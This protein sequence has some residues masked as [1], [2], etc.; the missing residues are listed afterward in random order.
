MLT[1]TILV[2]HTVGIQ[3]ASG[4]ASLEGTLWGD[5]AWANGSDWVGAVVI[6]TV[7]LW[8]DPLFVDPGSGDYHISAGSPARDEA[9]E[10]EVDRDIDNQL[11]SHPDTNIP[12][13]GADEYHLDDFRILL[14]LVVRSY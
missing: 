7:N 4:S 13:I 14:P 9:V 5:G 6:G 12:D 3:L 1:N 8:G 10:T 2:S 11:R